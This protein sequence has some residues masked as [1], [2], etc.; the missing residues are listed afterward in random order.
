V[1]LSNGDGSFQPIQLVLADFAPNA[2]G[3]HAD[4]HP[5]VMAD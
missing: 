4:R 3:W 1:A 2:N 5:R